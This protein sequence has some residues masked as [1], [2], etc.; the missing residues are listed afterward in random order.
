MYHIL[1]FV[2]VFLQILLVFNEILGINVCVL[3]ISKSASSF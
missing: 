2:N 1:V 3:T